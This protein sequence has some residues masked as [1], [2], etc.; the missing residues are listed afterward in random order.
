MWW[1][2]HMGEWQSRDPSGYSITER[3]GRTYLHDPSGGLLGT[4][5]GRP[6]AQYEAD[7]HSRLPPVEVIRPI[8]I[9]QSEEYTALVRLREE[10]SNEGYRPRIRTRGP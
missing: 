5:S 2:G 6:S 4:F 9:P 7:R 3:D 8:E 1:V 10:L